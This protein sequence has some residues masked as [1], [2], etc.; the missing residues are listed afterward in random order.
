MNQDGYDEVGFAVDNPPP[1]TVNQPN[2]AP[3]YQDGLSDIHTMEDSL[4]AF[5]MKPLQALKYSFTSRSKPQNYDTHQQRVLLLQ[6]H[7]LKNYRDARLSD[8]VSVR[9]KCD[10]S[11]L[12]S[13]DFYKINTPSFISS[14]WRFQYKWQVVYGLV[15]QSPYEP[16]ATKVSCE[17]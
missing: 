5:P 15:I 7:Y 12:L 11:I 8:S 6:I 14:Y 4:A 17:A 13:L 10:K 3:H 2:V 9:A 16:S 1:G